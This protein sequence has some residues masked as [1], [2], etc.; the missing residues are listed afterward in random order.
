[1]VIAQDRIEWI[2]YKYLQSLYCCELKLLWKLVVFLY[3]V[4]SLLNPQIRFL[5]LAIKSSPVS[6]VVTLP[7]FF[8]AS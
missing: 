1:M 8:F 5:K 4:L 7:G 2:V 6:N 3:E